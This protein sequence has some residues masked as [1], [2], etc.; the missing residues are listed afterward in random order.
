MY[1]LRSDFKETVIL[2]D[3]HSEVY[4]PLTPQELSD[5]RKRVLNGERITDIEM[6]KE[7]ISTLRQN[8]LSA[9]AASVEKKTKRK[10][11]KKMSDEELMDDLES[12][13]KGD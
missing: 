6:C 10:S 7:I 1:S 9:A 13:I 12:F 3:N 5:L 11:S 2:L 4:M 8:R